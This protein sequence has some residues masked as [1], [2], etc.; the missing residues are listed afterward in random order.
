MPIKDRISRGHEAVC[1][2]QRTLQTHGFKTR[3]FFCP[4]AMGQV[5]EAIKQFKDPADGRVRKIG[6]QWTI[7]SNAR[8][9]WKCLLDKLREANGF[10]D[11]PL[12]PE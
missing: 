8:E 3:E 6:F 2:A 4:K 10:D 1:D 5:V 12:S 7:F 11:V 9:A